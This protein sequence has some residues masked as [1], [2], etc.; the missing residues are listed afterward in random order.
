MRILTCLA[1]LTLSLSAF[2]QN[3]TSSDIIQPKVPQ[4]K[5]AAKPNA[6][7]QTPQQAGQP[8]GQN[9]N[10]R[11]VPV[12]RIPPFPKSWQGKWRGALNIYTMPNR[13][14][15]VPMTLEIKVTPNDTNRYNFILTYGADSIKGARNYEL[16]VLNAPRGIYQI[17]MK[18]SIKTEA[19]FI[20]N[21]LVSQFVIQGTRLITSY[22]RQGNFLIFDV[23]SGRDV[24]VSASGGGKAPNAAAN[25]PNLPVVQ[26]FP[27]GA[28]QRAVLTLDG[29]KPSP[30]NAKNTPAAKPKK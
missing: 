24:Y 20:M 16:V 27:L 5:P 28:W 9:P 23:I 30:A 4:A 14:Q 10:A 1:L 8:G 11:Q 29:A 18:N 2:A 19:F 25:A 12:I 21:R 15:R 13:F 7:G 26:T 22:E 3:P 6:P 17:D